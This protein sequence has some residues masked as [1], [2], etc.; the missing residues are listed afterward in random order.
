MSLKK[1][2][3]ELVARVKD[4]PNRLGSR[5]H[6]PFPVKKF[7][8]NDG[9]APSSIATDADPT[10]T[11]CG[12]NDPALRAGRRLLRHPTP[13]DASFANGPSSAVTRARGDRRD[14]SPPATGSA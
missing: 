3:G 13:P 1:R 7:L 9:S 5:V 10:P 6:V 8:C 4:L 11:S 14:R 12:A 2:D